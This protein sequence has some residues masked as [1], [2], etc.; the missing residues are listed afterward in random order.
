MS[1]GGGGDAKSL[2]S[3]PLV[4]GLARE[5]RSEIH[6]GRER[7]HIKSQIRW[8]PL[9]VWGRG[10]FGFSMPALPSAQGR[11]LPSECGDLPR[12]Q[13]LHRYPNLISI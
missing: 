8:G 4:M 10:G 5:E 13:V 7:G 6:V 2:S 11:V 9:P 12:S 3:R 1:P